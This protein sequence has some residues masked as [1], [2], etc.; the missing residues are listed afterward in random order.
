MIF[1]RLHFIGLYNSIAG[2]HNSQ[3]GDHHVLNKLTLWQ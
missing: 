2:L 3:F 1:G